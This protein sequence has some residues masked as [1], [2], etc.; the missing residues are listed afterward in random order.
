MNS[1]FIILAITCVFN[2]FGTKQCIQM[3]V[4]QI[5]A[6]SLNNVIGVHN[7]LPWHMP[8]DMAY[9]KEKTL[10]HHIVTGRRNYEAEGKALPGRVNIVLSRNPDY[11]IPDGIVV[12]KLEHAIDI[13]R[14]AG[15]TELFIVG[16]EQIYRL[17]MSV[18]DRIYLTRIHTVVEGDTFYPEPDR[19]EWKEVFCER[20][21]KD[22]SNPFDYDFLVYERESEN[23]TN[24]L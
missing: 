17:A 4:S 9:F 19:R 18:T 11:K 5:V 7:G 10:G 8:R 24:I 13:A 1:S 12:N 21:Q 14:K 22:E 20:H 3:I 6:A 23:K 2:T 16:G 15:E